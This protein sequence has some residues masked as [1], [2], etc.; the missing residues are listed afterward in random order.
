VLRK[1]RLWYS[2]EN[3]KA[4][5]KGTD[6]KRFYLLFVLSFAIAGLRLSATNS[7]EPGICLPEDGPLSCFCC[8]RPAL[9]I[10]PALGSA[11]LLAKYKYPDIPGL[12]RAGTLT[13]IAYLLGVF[14]GCND[15]CSCPVVWIKNLLNYDN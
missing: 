9:L 11:M 13:L 8:Y 5:K 15:F 2:A 4:Q 10:L 7:R 12:G 3:L 1:S 14:I 6:M